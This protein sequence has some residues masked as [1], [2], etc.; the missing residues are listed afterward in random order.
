MAKFRVLF[1]LRIHLDFVELKLCEHSSC[2]S[3]EKK[4]NSGILFPFNSL[5]CATNDIG[6]GCSQF[7]YH[8]AAQPKAA[9]V[10]SLAYLR[11]DL[12][13]LKVASS[14]S[15]VNTLKMSRRIGENCRAEETVVI[16]LIVIIKNIILLFT[17]HS[18]YQNVAFTIIYI[19]EQ[20]YKVNRF[21]YV[22]VSVS[23]TYRMSICP[24]KARES[25][26]DH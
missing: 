19:L 20:R 6:H 22:C 24:S 13:N 5:T 14:L 11:L 3:T 8:T 18:A 12:D 17:G 16:I 10:T 4:L 9:S 7:S 1:A 23:Q 25:S 21:N 15:L 2:L 26:E